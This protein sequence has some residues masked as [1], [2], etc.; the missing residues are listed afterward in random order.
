MTR[1][2][3][4]NELK[5]RLTEV[6]G[7]IMKYSQMNDKEKRKVEKEIEV[8]LARKDVHNL[9]YQILVANSSLAQFKNVYQQKYQSLKVP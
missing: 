6:Y 5:K 7:K 9:N 3:N 1:I 2:M 8:F 4:G